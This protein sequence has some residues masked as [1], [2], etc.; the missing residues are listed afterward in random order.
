MDKIEAIGSSLAQISLYDIKSYYNQAKAVVLNYTEMEAKVR[1]ATNDDPWGASSTVMQEIAQGTFNFQQF[2]EIMPTIYKR[3]TE[4]EAREWRQIYKALQLLEYL[5]KHGSERVIDD[6]RSHISMI[7]VLRSFHYIDEKA[8]DQGINVRNRAKEIAELLSD[9]DRVRQERRKA[10]ASRNKYTGVGNEGPSFTSATGSKYGGFGSDTGGFSG[11]GGGGGDDWNNGG[12]SSSRDNYNGGSSSFKQADDFEEY[13]AGEWEDRPS[14]SNAQKTVSPPPKGRGSIS[15]TRV[16]SVTKKAQEK[17]AVPAP[18]AKE[19]DLFSFDDDE[20][21]APPLPSATSSKAP[22][23]GGNSLAGLDDDFDDFQSAPPTVSGGASI[24]QTSSSQPASKPDVFALLNAS[25]TQTTQPMSQQPVMNNFSA[26]S[27]TSGQSMMSPPAG[28]PM[29][30]AAMMQPMMGNGMMGNGMMGNNR[31]PNM[32]S[33]NQSMA[34]FGTPMTSSAKPPPSGSTA[35]KPT[36]SANFD[37]LF[38]FAGMTSGTSAQGNKPAASKVS[39][40]T[41]AR[42]QSSASIWGGQNG[43]PMGSV[44]GGMMGTPLNQNS[45]QSSSFANSTSNSNNDDLLL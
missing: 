22:T 16:S 42:E 8:K 39:M 45:N 32:G 27:P 4:K 25:S 35:T 17:A 9:L 38:S 2:N 28:Q 29:S 26:F 36:N 13:D 7:K 24:A 1:E 10:K 15:N 18:K 5:I 34:N 40:A 23:L 31:A 21:Q 37:D 12:G 20:D 44:G 3:F 14:G 43:K 19:V 30:N 11:G 41:M 6:A 33:M